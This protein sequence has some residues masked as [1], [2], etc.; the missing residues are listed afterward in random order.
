MSAAAQLPE[1]FSDLEPL[2]EAGWCLGT[3]QQR[4]AK[5]ESSSPRELRAFYE[6]FAPR[7]EAVIAYLDDEG[8]SGLPDLDRNLEFLLMAMAEVSFAVEKLGADHSTYDGIP[9]DRFV[10]VHELKDQGLPVPVEYRER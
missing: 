8:V 10:P 7:L 6:A 4:L 9:G 3:E 2:A 1:T 5:R